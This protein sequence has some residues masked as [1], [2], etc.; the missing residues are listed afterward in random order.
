ME[1][2]LN[3]IEKRA[4]AAG[5]EEWS[6]TVDATG[7]AFLTTGNHEY[8]ADVGA[9]GE[10]GI[11]SDYG[12]FIAAANPVVVL[13]L[14]RRLREAEERIERMRKALQIIAAMRNQAYYKV[15]PNETAKDAHL[16]AFGALTEQQTGDES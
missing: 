13:E 9:V 15:C 6:V 12:R 10:E 5:G 11:V 14:V 7:D 1:I 4:Q 8:V 16:I 3:E 2:D